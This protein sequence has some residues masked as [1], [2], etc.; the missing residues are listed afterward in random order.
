[1]SESVIVVGAGIV[2]LCVAYHLRRYGTAVT[3]IDRAPDGDK[4]SYGNAAGIAVTEIVPASVPGLI[5]RVPG[6]L[7][8]PL[9]PLA[10][11]PAHALAL[12]PWLVRFSRMGRAAEVD[13]IASALAA[14]NGRVYDD[15]R[16]MLAETGL[17][18]ELNERGALTVYETEQGFRRDAAE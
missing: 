15:L 10:I 14:L 18:S 2:G 3:V 4:A 12:L 11:R 7:I 6:W 8:D 1:V 5:W 9:G 16:P 13:R 17:L